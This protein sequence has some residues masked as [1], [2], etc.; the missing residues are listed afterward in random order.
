MSIAAKIKQY[1]DD[2]KVE[3]KVLTHPRAYTAQDTAAAAHVP[4]RELAKSVVVKAD[5]RFVLAVLPA[6]RKIDLEKL[7]KILGVSSIRLAL[8]SEFSS[9]FPGCEA[10]AMPPFG[11]LYGVQVFVDYSL[12]EDDD[13]VFNASTHEEAIR[14]KYADFE[15]LITPTV[16]DF[17]ATTS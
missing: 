12:T 3:Y 10:G 2:N 16:A 6:P 15:R 11:S 14:M 1:L 17:A 7:K 4:G 8:E 13:I 5:D 9:S